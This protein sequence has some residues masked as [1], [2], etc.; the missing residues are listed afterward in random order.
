MHTYIHIYICTHI[1]NSLLSEGE[2]WR[3]LLEKVVAH[4]CSR[5]R[6]RACQN[7]HKISCLFKVLHDMTTQVNL[8][9]LYLR[10]VD[11]FVGAA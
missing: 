11:G 8:E 3:V 9:N 4:K 1:I 2:P 10:I 5:A 7:S 6:F